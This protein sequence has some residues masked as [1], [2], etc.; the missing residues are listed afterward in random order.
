MKYKCKTFRS[1]INKTCTNVHVQILSLYANVCRSLCSSVG[2]SP[3]P[4]CATIR[5]R[6]F[7]SGSWIEFL[8]SIFFT[9]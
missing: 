1:K 8:F 6:T 7:D 4:E 9:V 2:L 5:D 3:V